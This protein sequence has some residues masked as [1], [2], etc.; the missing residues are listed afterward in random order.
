MK[1]HINGFVRIVIFAIVCILVIR[2]FFIP[3]SDFDYYIF[4]DISECE[5]FKS[6]SYEEGEIKVFE[7]A[8]TDKYI[9]SLAYEE[10]YVAEYTSKEISFEIY[11][12]RFRSREI[13]QQY[14]KNVTGKSNQPDI[15]FSESRGMF[16]SVLT[17]IDGE[18]A[19][20]IKTKPSCAKEVYS[21]IGTVFSEKIN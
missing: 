16:W 19:Y 10:F 18:K 5:K 2:A 13:A 21:M 9:N 7:S 8:D 11:A 20:C 12:Y 6:L 4:K 1:K 15:S 14:F 3:K 17:V